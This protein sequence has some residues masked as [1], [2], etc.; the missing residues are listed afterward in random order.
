MIQNARCGGRF[1]WHLQSLC[2]SISA[3]AAALS[4]C[5][6]SRSFNV[7]NRFIIG[8]S[9]LFFTHTQH[10][11]LQ[12][13]PPA[14]PD[15]QKQFPTSEKYGILQQ[16]NLHISQKYSHERIDTPCATAV[17][18]QRTHR[19]SPSF[20]NLSPYKLN[21]QKTP[22]PASGAFCAFLRLQKNSAPAS[23]AKSPPPAR[24]PSAPPSSNNHFSSNISFTPC[25]YCRENPPEIKP[26]SPKYT[27][28]QKTI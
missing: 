10:R 11:S 6:C 15:H 22:L 23:A 20:F 8:N 28:I 19:L 1:L 13:A 17:N 12:Q 2:E 3:S 18:S 7:K 5:S 16:G 4:P 26:P 21:A 24:S 25:S 9:S 27:Q 14:A